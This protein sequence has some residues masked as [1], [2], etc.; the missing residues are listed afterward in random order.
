MRETLLEALVGRGLALPGVAFLLLGAAVF[1]VASRLAQGGPAPRFE[2]VRRHTT[3]HHTRGFAASMGVDDGNAFHEA[4]VQA[5]IRGFLHDSGRAGV[6]MAKSALQ[7]GMLRVVI[8][9]VEATLPAP[10]APR[11]HQNLRLPDERA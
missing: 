8:S 4:S 7:P 10:N 5:V 9:P 1:L 6:K 2:L 3:E 11:P